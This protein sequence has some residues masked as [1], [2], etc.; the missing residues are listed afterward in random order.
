M[1]RKFCMLKTVISILI[2]TCC[3]FPISAFSIEY[4]HGIKLKEMSFSWKIKN[5][6]IFIKLTATTTGWVGI[7]L[8]PSERM[9]DANFILGFVKDGKAILSDAYGVS[10]REHIKDT[11]M[12]GKNNFADVSG[13]E[14]GNLTTIEFSI[15]MDSGDVADRKIN[16]DGFTTVLLAFGKGSDDFHSRHRFR[17]SL[18]VNL[19]TGEYQ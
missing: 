6:L 12:N 18:K 1:K 19:A 10:P 17:T 2:I 3:L 7:G 11:S 9:R 16:V 4:D 14:Q 5:Q 13:K 15:P 8:N